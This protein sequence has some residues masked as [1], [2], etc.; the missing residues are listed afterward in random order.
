MAISFQDSYQK[1]QFIT[2]DTTA[3]TLTQLKQDINIGYKRFDAAISRYF[4]RTQKFANLV[5][6]QKYYQ[7]PVDAIRVTEVSV[8]ISGGYEY[9]LKQVRSENDWRLMNIVPNFASNYITHYFV[10]GNDQI[11]LFPTP[12]ANVTNGIRFVYQ[13]QDVDLTQDDYITGTATVSASG[14]AV[15]GTGTSWTSAMVGRQFQITDGSDGQWYEITAVGSATSLTLKTPYN[16]S[17]VSGAKYRISQVFIF[18]GEY[19]DVPV[20]YSLSRFF[21]FRNN[22]NRATYHTNRY[23]SAVEDALRRYAS[24]STSNVIT[25]DDDTLSFN[26]W[27]VPPMP[28]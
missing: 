22:P 26:W 16:G 11:G 5:A 7:T 24:S 15:T 10:Y 28:G 2:G 23:T 27:Q 3:A 20:D 14:T 21:E 18:P 1:A 25:G 9:P 13:P 17:S 19:D 8:V 4:T 6:S 12:S